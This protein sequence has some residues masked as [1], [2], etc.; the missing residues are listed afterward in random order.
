M[1]GWDWWAHCLLKTANFEAAVVHLPEPPRANKNEI[2]NQ[3]VVHQVVQKVVQQVVQ[4]VVQQ[5]FQYLL[6]KGKL[7]KLKDALFAVGLFVSCRM[8]F[9]KR[10]SLRRHEMSGTIVFCW[11]LGLKTPRMR[12]CAVSG[13]VIGSKYPVC[14]QLFY[15]MLPIIWLLYTAT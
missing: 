14:H 3:Q 6:C 9:G 11:T 5:V 7:F 12:V 10:H 13:N 4:K 1:W 2:S 15:T 8:W